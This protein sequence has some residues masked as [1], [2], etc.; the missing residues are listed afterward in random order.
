M[1]QINL[2]SK[3]SLNMPT[4]R[5]KFNK[6]VKEKFGGRSEQTGESGPNSML[7]IMLQWAQREPITMNQITLKVIN[8]FMI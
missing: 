8:N 3:M 5:M 6:T 7:V 4:G 2:A 1:A